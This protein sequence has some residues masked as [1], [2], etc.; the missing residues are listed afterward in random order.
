M[1]AALVLIATACNQQ[2]RPN[3]DD[4]TS[5]T[6]TL[7]NPVGGTAVSLS[8]TVQGTATDDQAV[9]RVT[10]QLGGSLE[11]NVPITPAA[12]VPFSFNVQLQ[13]G[14]NVIV[15]NAYDAAGNIG[16]ATLS[17][18]YGT[19]GGTQDTLRPDISILSPTP[20]STVNSSSVSVQGKAKDNLAVTRIAYQLNGKAEQNISFTP[21]ASVDFT[22]TVSGLLPGSNT[23]IFNAYDA[24]GNKDSASTRVVYSGSSPSPT[25]SPAPTPTPTPTG[26][27]QPALVKAYWINKVLNATQTQVSTQYMQYRPRQF[28]AGLS[29]IVDPAPQ[30]EPDFKLDDPGVYK[31]WDALIMP[32]NGSYVAYTSSDNMLELYLNRE[33]RVGLVWYGSPTDR[34]SW[35]SDWT[36]GSTVQAGGK[37]YTVFLKNLP[38]GRNLL[39]GIDRKAGRVYTV[40]LA[41]KDSKPSSPP[42][43]PAG[44]E[45]PK[46]NTACPD[47]VHD[48]YMVKGFDGKMYRTWHPQIDPVYWCYF[49]HEHGSDPSQLPGLKAAMDRGDLRAA[50]GYVSTK[51]GKDE[52]HTGFK[53]FAYD[54]RQGHDWL[55][56]FHIGT[57]GR[58]RLCTRYHEYNLWVVDHSSGELLAELHYMTDTGPALDASATGTP[59]D[60]SKAN[61]TRYKP[62]GCPDN[63]SIPMTGENG[64]RRIPRIDR[65][66]YETWQPSLPSTLGLFGGRGYNTDNPQTR[67]SA[68]YD[69]Q[70]NPTCDQMV[71]SPSDYDWGENRWFIIADGAT[72]GFGIDASK[73]LATGVFYTDPYGQ[74]LLPSSDPTAVRQ[75]IKPGL[76]VRHLTEDRWIP[77]DG[78]WVQYKPVPSG[79]VNFESHNLEHSLQVPN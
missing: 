64:R 16:S 65:N 48:Q 76:F 39:R 24:A 32:A 60:P 14:Q 31:G 2:A 50:F 40:L 5:P 21:G 19:T 35:M 25:P 17:I 52:P 57:G 58:G 36:P 53:L 61:T 28:N 12:R 1:W 26:T 33:A 79:A 23:I 20:G 37:T 27:A 54:D 66:G 69:A 3:T 51:A 73:A 41:E 63:L 44:L 72:T 71:R 15:V 11:Q 10:Y 6:I 46:P 8:L 74:R 9:T 43:V 7:E 42:P 30:Q 78:W 13:T 67:C 70:G 22:A 34:P 77:Y 4:Q 38:A 56:Q 49:G 62:E 47:W 68:S 59:D 55:I 29:L 18:T 45:V 75:Y